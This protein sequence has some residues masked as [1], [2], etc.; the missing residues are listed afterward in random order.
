MRIKVKLL[1]NVSNLLGDGKTVM[2]GEVVELEADVATRQ[3]GRGL[4]EEVRE[5]V[6]KKESLVEKYMKE[7][8]EETP[9]RKK[10]KEKTKKI[11]KKK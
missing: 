2:A 9:T 3:I 11:T 1:V 5:V 7:K 4:V 8:K 10:D 6:Q